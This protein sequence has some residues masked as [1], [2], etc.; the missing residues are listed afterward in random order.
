MNNEQQIT[1]VHIMRQIDRLFSKL[2]EVGATKI[3]PEL[4][5]TIQVVEGTVVITHTLIVGAKTIAEYKQVLSKTLEEVKSEAQA[6]KDAL[7]AQIQ[8]SVAELDEII[9]L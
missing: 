9:N 2:K 6:Q 5:R 8:P 7:Q 1:P 3:D 4:S